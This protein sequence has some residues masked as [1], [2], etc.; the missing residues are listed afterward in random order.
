MRTTISNF[1]FS[2][3]RAKKFELQKDKILFETEMVISSSKLKGF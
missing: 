2:D 3:K 1:F